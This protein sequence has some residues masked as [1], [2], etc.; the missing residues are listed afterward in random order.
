MVLR[1]SQP[2]RTAALARTKTL[3]FPHLAD[4]GDTPRDHQD[5][6]QPILPTHVFIWLS[7]ACG[8]CEDSGEEAAEDNAA[9]QVRNASQHDLVF[10]QHFQYKTHVKGAKKEEKEKK[11][12]EGFQGAGSSLARVA[13]KQFLNMVICLWHGNN[14]ST[15]SYVSQRRLLRASTHS[16]TWGVSE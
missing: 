13:W 10:W 9:P 7:S 12:A 1:T 2:L 11:L 3:S 4:Q 14:F 5:L 6:P 15:W 16:L 8:A